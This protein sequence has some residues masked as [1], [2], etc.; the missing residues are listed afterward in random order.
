MTKRVWEFHHKPR[1][2]RFLV[3]EG[4]IYRAGSGEHFM[5]LKRQDDKNFPWLAVCEDGTVHNFT[6]TGRY[7]KEFGYHKRHLVKEIINVKWDD[8]AARSS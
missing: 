8:I 3:Y 7:T 1:K 6:D 4:G 2:R 5:I